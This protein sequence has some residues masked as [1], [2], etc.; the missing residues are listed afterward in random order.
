MQKLLDHLVANGNHSIPLEHYAKEVIQMMQL[1][2]KKVRKSE[3]IY[4][5]LGKPQTKIKDTDPFGDSSGK[6]T[7]NMDDVKPP[8]KNN[9]VGGVQGNMYAMSVNHPKKGMM[10]VKHQD[11]HDFFKKSAGDPHLNLKGSKLQ[12]RTLITPNGTSIKIHDEELLNKFKNSL[13]KIKVI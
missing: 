6:D 2:I 13:N 8:V 10:N 7:I 5:P 1:L 12:G 3:L 4:Q 11:V 9:Y